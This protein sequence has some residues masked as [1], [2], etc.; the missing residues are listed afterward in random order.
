MAPERRK[1]AI[2]P[3]S[4]QIAATMV[5]NKERRKWV[6]AIVSLWSHAVPSAYQL[7]H[8]HSVALFVA[9]NVLSCAL[10]IWGI[11]GVNCEIYQDT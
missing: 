1:Q 10:A 3:V 5:G 9:P 8:L 6:K 11:H 2:M 4:G 7:Y